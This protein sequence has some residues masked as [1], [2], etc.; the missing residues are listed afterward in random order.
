MHAVFF[1]FPMSQL[2]PEAGEVLLSVSSTTT[3]ASSSQPHGPQGSVDEEKQSLNLTAASTCISPSEQLNGSVKAAEDARQDANEGG[4]R[5]V[6][7]LPP[8]Y[9]ADGSNTKPSSR[10]FQSAS[11]SSPAR[12]RMVAGG[13]AS[14]GSRRGQ[15]TSCSWSRFQTAKS[16][17]SRG[18]FLS[19]SSCASSGSAACPM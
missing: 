4:A 7:A 10:C 11:S 3:P 14:S 1:H 13:V 12:A 16:P 2:S 18:S 8:D 5:R 19:R 15:S 6:V 9:E 17:S